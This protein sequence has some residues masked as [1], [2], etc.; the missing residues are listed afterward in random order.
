MRILLLIF[1]ATLAPSPKPPPPLSVSQSLSPLPPMSNQNP[2]TPPSTSTG[3][4]PSPDDTGDESHYPCGTCDRSVNF[5]TKGVE[6]EK[7]GQWFH[8]GC[9]SYP[10]E[11]YENL[12]SETSWRCIICDHHNSTT[13]FNLYDLDHLSSHHLSNNNSLHS[14]GAFKPIHSSTPTNTYRQDKQKHRPLRFLNINFQSVT[15]K[16]PQLT[17]LVDSSKPDIIFATESHL[18]K[19]IAS[20]EFTPNNYSMFR[21]DRNRDGGGV[22][23]ATASSLQCQEVPELSVP[24]CELIWVKV[25]TKSRPLLVASYYRPVVSDEESLKLFTESLHK[26][27]T[28][29]HN[30]HIIVGGDFNFPS[31]DWESKQLKPP[32]RYPNLHYLFLDTLADFGLEQM[33]TFPTRDGNTLDL[34]LTNSPHLVPRTESLPPISAKADHDIVYMEFQINPTRQRSIRRKIPLYNK[35]PLED[36]LKPAAIAL[37]DSLTNSPTN[38]L[39]TNG[40]WTKFK[41]GLDEMVNLYVPF[42]TTRPKPDKPWVDYGLRR[43]IRR[44]DRHYKKWRKSG[45]EEHRKKMLSLKR[46]VQRR[47]RQ[48][49][50]SYTEKL[51]CGSNDIETKKRFWSYVK[52]KS[53]QTSNVAPLKINGRLVTDAKERAEALNQQFQK[54][55]SEESSCS[56]EDFTSRTGLSVDEEGQ[57]NTITITEEG[58]RKLLKALNPAKAPGPDG[59]SPRLL[60]DLADELAPALTLIFQSSLDSGEVPQDWR[61]A[62]VTPIFKKGQ[63]YDPA[64]YRPISLTSV[65]CKILE[66]ILVSTIMTYAESNDIL[67]DE[68]HGFRR[69]RSCETQL[70]GFVDEVSHSLEKGGQIDTIVMDFSKAFDK[71]S[72]S[73]LIHK[74]KHLG[75]AGPINRWIASFL[76]DRKQAVVVEGAISNYV[77]VESGV[78]QGSVLGPSLFLLYINDLPSNLASEA[79]LFADDTLCHHPISSTEDQE[80]LQDDIR[81]LEKWEE[82][83]RMSFNPDKCETL[84]ITRKR[85][86]LPTEYSLHEKP[87]QPVKKAK[88][89][90]VTITQDLRWDTH[91]TNVTNRANQKLGLLR[92]TLKV[93]SIRAKEQAYKAL[94][95]PSLEYASA[96]WDP[97]N[98]KEV[99]KLERVQR[100]AARWVVRRFRQTSS[101]SEMLE[102]LQWPPLSQRRRCARLALMF[103]Y[104]QGLIKIRSKAKPTPQP[105]LRSSRK[106]NQAAYSHPSCRTEYRKNSF[107]PRTV[108]EWNNLPIE[109]VTTATVEAFKSQI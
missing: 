51:I 19:N 99:S 75:I 34:F 61:T 94:V 40:L 57:C 82:T 5:D 28:Y 41:D 53:T 37:S 65:P 24:N 13:L 108:A 62:Y 2:A 1:A 58:V 59:I 89:L 39:N 92:R 29:H 30:A 93:S 56:A 60:R 25:K 106:T 109:A 7:C 47:L 45:S 36:K 77:R 100:R 102:Q 44:R 20:C 76:S 97:Y 21:C 88:Y 3:Q 84:T 16:V 78:P 70:I 42:T 26:A 103:K 4:A 80:T 23:I 81:K 98:D 22:F 67:C 14:P 95:R 32:I 66:H 18:D 83:W 11:D 72:H 101:V 17:N 6:C 87:L 91:V 46:Q 55:F 71:V 85:S 52:A 9:Q 79:R 105:P 10:S 73:L 35:A 27:C 48:A 54:A 43:L 68:Q 15:G 74:L 8:I 86:P 49:Y 96:V 12:N 33:I 38:S 104:H 31:L 50:W 107:F 69:G 63:H 64:N 90:G